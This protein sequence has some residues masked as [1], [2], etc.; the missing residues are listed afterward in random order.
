MQL[1][2]E[3]VAFVYENIYIGQGTVV[4]IHS[5]DVRDNM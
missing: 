3:R 2:L 4:Y 1:I 5:T